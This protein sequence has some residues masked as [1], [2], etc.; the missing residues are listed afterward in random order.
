M[1]KLFILLSLVFLFA[2]EQDSFTWHCETEVWLYNGRDHR[3]LDQWSV[4]FDATEEEAQMYE[5][6][7]SSVSDTI[8]VITKCHR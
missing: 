6:K 3:L 2:C 4:T 1:K 5:E 7:C 8:R